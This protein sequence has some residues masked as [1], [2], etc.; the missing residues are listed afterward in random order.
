MHADCWFHIAGFLNIKER[1]RLYVVIRDVHHDWSD[2]RLY[3]FRSDRGCVKRLVRR[4]WA[5]LR[6]WSFLHEGRLVLPNYTPWSCWSPWCEAKHLYFGRFVVRVRFE[7]GYSEEH[8]AFMDWLGSLCRHSPRRVSLTTRYRCDSPWKVP[9]RDGM[10]DVIFLPVVFFRVRVRVTQARC[11][12][13]LREAATLTIDRFEFEP[14][15]AS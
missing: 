1:G 7:R 12:R 4:N 2:L 13:V 8:A 3:Y 9:M 5:F 6:Q 14:S 10:K 15:K 11:P